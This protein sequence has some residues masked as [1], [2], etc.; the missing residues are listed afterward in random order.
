MKEEKKADYALIAESNSIGMVFGVPSAIRRTMRKIM[1]TENG[2]E[3]MAFVLD[4]GKTLF[5][6]MK[7]CVQNAPLK[8][9]R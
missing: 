5:L 9:M 2:I 3:I 6:E 1:P 4:A 7:I 8:C